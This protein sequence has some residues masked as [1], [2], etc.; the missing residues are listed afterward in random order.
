MRGYLDRGG[1]TWDADVAAMAVAKLRVAGQALSL[2]FDHGFKSLALV[3]VLALL[4]V[5]YLR[6]PEGEADREGIAR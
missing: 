5:P 6:S 4:L 2:A 1:F 3:F